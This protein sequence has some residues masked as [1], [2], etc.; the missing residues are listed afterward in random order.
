M[1]RSFLDSMV[2][3]NAALAAGLRFEILSGE[4]VAFRSATRIHIWQGGPYRRV[5]LALARRL[6]AEQVIGA[7]EGCAGASLALDVLR[8]F[9]DQ[10]IVRTRGNKARPRVR[11][12]GRSRPEFFG[13][14]DAPYRTCI[15]FELWPGANPDSHGPGYYVYGK[16]VEGRDA[17]IGC[18]AEA[19]ERQSV[20]AAKRRKCVRLSPAEIRECAVLPHLLVPPGEHGTGV[21]THWTPTRSLV[22][23]RRVF[24]PSGYCYSGLPARIAGDVLGDS[25][26]CAAGPTVTAAAVNG[27]LEVM[28]RDALRHWWIGRNPARPVRIESFASAF[29]GDVRRY[30]ALRGRNL[31]VL[32]VSH[33]RHVPVFAALSFDRGGRGVLG[34]CAHFEPESA[35]RGAILELGLALNWA[36]MCRVGS[37]GLAPA[38]GYQ[39]GAPVDWSDF[40]TVEDYPGPV[41]GDAESRLDRAAALMREW[42][43]DLLLLD[44]SQ[45]GALYRTVRV[46]V[47]GLLRFNPGALY[48]LRT[49]ERSE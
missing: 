19:V 27:F 41:P 34:A 37:R 23:G 18:G 12:G 15:G 28:E 11:P 29:P 45:P 3:R 22:S 16:G 21:P 1:A 42:R 17:M 24:L 6:T 26:G 44:V 32:D 35:M 39:P 10:R 38:I 43:R 33:T 48:G 46:T 5:G 47:P 30:L 13:D 9:S 25:T 7:E 2:L 36:G 20:Q 49:P 8:Q 31:L 4:S 40:R 14:P